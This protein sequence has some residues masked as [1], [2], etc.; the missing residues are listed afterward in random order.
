MRGHEVNFRYIELRIICCLSINVLIIVHSTDLVTSLKLNF[1]FN[2]KAV[3]FSDRQRYKLARVQR[4]LYMSY[5]FR[6]LND[7]SMFSFLGK[8][9]SLAVSKTFM[10]AKYYFLTFLLIYIFYIKYITSFHTSPL[11]WKMIN[12]K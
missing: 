12:A 9:F 10:I 1:K 2:D 3:T 6:Q 5:N 4:L 8:L 7:C 11:V